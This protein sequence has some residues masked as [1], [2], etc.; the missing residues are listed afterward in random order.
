MFCY[1]VGA[2]GIVAAFGKTST[3]E[4]TAIRTPDSIVHVFPPSL[5]I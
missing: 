2:A 4:V 1:F 5:V 3:G